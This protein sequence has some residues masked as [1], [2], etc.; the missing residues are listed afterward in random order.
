MFAIGE[1][2]KGGLYGAYPDLEKLDD[3]DPI[4]TTDFRQVYATALDG[5]LNVPSQDILGSRFQAI[6]FIKNRT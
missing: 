5:W 1:G 2:V 6:P 4:M 3:G